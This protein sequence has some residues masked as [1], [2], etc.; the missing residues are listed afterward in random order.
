MRL[1][2][3]AQYSVRAGSSGD[4]VPLTVWCRTMFVQRNLIRCATSPR[5]LMIAR[6]PNTHRSLLNLL[7]LPK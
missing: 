6:S 3:A 4:A 1:R 2:R 7:N 5:A